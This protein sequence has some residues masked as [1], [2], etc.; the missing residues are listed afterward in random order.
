MFVTLNVTDDRIGYGMVRHPISQNI[1]L[2][3]TFG[4]Y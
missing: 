1:V 4:G 2:D 3:L